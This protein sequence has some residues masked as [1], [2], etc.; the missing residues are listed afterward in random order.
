MMIRQWTLRTVILTTN[1][2]GGELHY[3]VHIADVGTK[4]RG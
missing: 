3:T 1:R 4:E 2:Q